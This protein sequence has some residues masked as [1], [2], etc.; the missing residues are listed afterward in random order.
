MNTPE[1]RRFSTRQPE[2][3]AGLG[4]RRRCGTAERAHRRG[5]RG[6][7]ATRAAIN[8]RGDGVAKPLS[9]RCTTGPRSRRRP[10]PRSSASTASRGCSTSARLGRFA[11]A[12]AEREPGLVAV[13][14]D[15]PNVLP[16]TREYIA[17]RPQ[18]PRHHGRRDYLV[19]PLPEGST[20]LPVGGD[21]QHSPAE[22]RAHRV[23][24]AALNPGAGWP[25]ST[26]HGRRSGRAPAAPFFALNMLVATESR[27]HVHEA[28][29]GL[30]AKRVSPAAP[31]STLARHRI[32]VARSSRAD[33]EDVCGS[34]S[35][36]AITDL[37]MGRS[38]SC[39]RAAHGRQP[40][41]ASAFGPALAPH[42]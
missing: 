26:G 8:E 12:F 33:Q 25:W 29:S 30:D 39:S 20:R 11:M 1:S 42:S 36:D 21:S 32:V 4:T 27:R 6:R 22:R 24:A 2:F 9:R 5:P 19:D 38:P 41:R 14:F 23:C 31:G 15:L 13:V 40:A 18:Q 10:S 35:D 17:G 3:A 16:L 37:V 34:P 7:P 28:E